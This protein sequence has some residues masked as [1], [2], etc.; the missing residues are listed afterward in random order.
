SGGTAP[1]TY[2]VSID[3]GAYSSLGAITSPF[4]YS[5][6]DA[7]TYR[8]R[9]TD[10]TGCQAVPNVITI[11]PLTLPSATTTVVK[12]SCYGG[13]EGSFRSIPSG[14]VGPDSYSID[15]GTTFT[16]TFLYSGL[17]VGA[18]A[19]IVRDANECRFPGAVYIGEPNALEATAT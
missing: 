1:F 12:V 17:A 2:E 14:G 15:G 10:A 9:V 8:F 13:N 6:S 18:C 11:S 7:G 19:Y 4:T 3:G 16:S 5:T